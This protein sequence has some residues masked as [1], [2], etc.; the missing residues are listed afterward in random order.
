M[1]Q[2]DSE[3]GFITDGRTLMRPFFFEAASATTQANPT[4]DLWF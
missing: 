2:Q 4:C 3:F 1:L